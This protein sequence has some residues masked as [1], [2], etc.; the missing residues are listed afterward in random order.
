PAH[1]A[2]LSVEVGERGVTPF[3]PTSAFYP[4]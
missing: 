4:R 1:Q 3:I 2:I